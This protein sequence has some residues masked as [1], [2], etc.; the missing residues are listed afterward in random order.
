MTDWVCTTCGTPGATPVP[1]HTLI[2][3]RYAVGYCDRCTQE[4][5]KTPRK[6]RRGTSHLIRA[7]LFDEGEFKAKK[8]KAELA[9]YVGLFATGKDRIQL[10]NEQ[11]VRLV[12][13][14]DRHGVKGFALPEWCR[15]AAALKTK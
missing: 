7:D 10:S 4:F 3:V 8:E 5:P 2:D 15:E 6:T 12:E 9:G 13:L 14:Y 11:V 1:G